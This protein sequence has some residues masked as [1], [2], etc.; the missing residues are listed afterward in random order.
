MKT[1]KELFPGCESKYGF[2]APYGGYRLIFENFGDVLIEVEE[3]NYQGMTYLLIKKDDFYALDSY[4]WGSCP[5]CDSL[6]ACYSYENLQELMD[7]FASEIEWMT[8]EE[9]IK[10]VNGRIENL[11]NCWREEEEVDFLNQVKEY[12]N[13]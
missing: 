3:D 12:F 9:I 13:R 6:Q 8:K 5:G 4:R 11:D 1:A 7:K 10:E 2:D